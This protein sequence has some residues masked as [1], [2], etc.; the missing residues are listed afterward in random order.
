MTAKAASCCRRTSATDDGWQVPRA[1]CSSVVSTSA[2]SSF[3]RARTPDATHCGWQPGVRLQASRPAP[4]RPTARSVPAPSP[5]RAPRRGRPI[6][7]GP[8]DRARAR[9]VARGWRLGRERHRAAEDH[10]GHAAGETVAHARSLAACGASRRRAIRTRGARTAGPSRNQRRTRGGGIGGFDR[11]LRRGDQRRRIHARHDAGEAL[12]RRHVEVG[13]GMLPQL[14][15]PPR[16]RAGR[17][18]TRGPWSSRRRRR[19]RGRCG[20]GSE[21]R[22]RDRPC[23]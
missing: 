18:D 5:P 2:A 3:S 1:I 14:A 6:R 23:G 22:R 20:R 21:S 17:C 7:P 8:A 16:W 19:R 12:Q 11:R 13:A 10:R 15:R 9:G 4:A